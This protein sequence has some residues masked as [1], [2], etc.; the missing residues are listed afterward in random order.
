MDYSYLVMFSWQIKLNWTVG[1][2]LE[3]FTL[4][5]WLSCVNWTVYCH[6]PCFRQIQIWR[7][8]G[9]R[10]VYILAMYFQSGRQAKV[11]W[12]LL[13]YSAF[14][15]RWCLSSITLWHPIFSFP[16]LSKYLYFNNNR[17]T[18]SALWKCHWRLCLKAWIK[19]FLKQR[20]MNQMILNKHLY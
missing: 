9:Y 3:C 4:S 20:L 17:S 16:P 18:K 2:L 14:L 6:W 13:L 5:Q 15:L 11:E 19:L 12:L 7:M 10:S 8:Y 1:G